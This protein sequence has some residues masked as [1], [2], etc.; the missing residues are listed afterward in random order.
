MRVMV[1]RNTGSRH[2]VS[3]VGSLSERLLKYV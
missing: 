3:A 1:A 2:G